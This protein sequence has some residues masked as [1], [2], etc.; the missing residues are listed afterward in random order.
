MP[1]TKLP[2]GLW[3]P[4]GV[5]GEN[6]GRTEGAA[7]RLG[8]ALQGPW[9]WASVPTN[10]HYRL[11]ACFALNQNPCSPSFSGLVCLWYAGRLPSDR[12]QGL[13]SGQD[14]RVLDKS[15]AHFWRWMEKGLPGEGTE[16]LSLTH[17]HLER[18]FWNT[19]VEGQTYI[20]KHVCIYLHT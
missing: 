8:L 1:R 14:Y 15:A 9:A 17:R 13:L 12:E 7:R 19:G 20:N 3:G 6:R 2:A 5:G 10:P 11:C 18:M 16:D 4:L